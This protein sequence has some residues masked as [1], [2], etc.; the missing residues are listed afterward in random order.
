MGVSIS[1]NLKRESVFINPHGTV[2]DRYDKQT[3]QVIK[4][5]N[6]LAEGSTSMEALRKAKGGKF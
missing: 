4:G 5:T 3:K 6:V 2:Q 1:K